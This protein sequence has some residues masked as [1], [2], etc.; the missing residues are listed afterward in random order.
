MA[1]VTCPNCG[2]AAESPQSAG[3]IPFCLECGWHV[4]AN[5]SLAGWARRL[6][7]IIVLGTLIL[8]LEIYGT[9]TFQ[10][11]SEAAWS[12]VFFAFL[13]W[14]AY[15][16][17][18]KHMK[19]LCSACLPNGVAASQADWT[20]HPPWATFETIDPSVS[21]RVARWAA[22]PKPRGVTYRADVMWPTAAVLGV[23]SVFY[24]APQQAWG[25]GV[26]LGPGYYM[27]LV[28]VPVLV[29]FAW[30]Q[31]YARE[32]CSRRMLAEG[33]MTTGRIL[34]RVPISIAPRGLLG[35]VPISASGANKHHIITYKYWRPNGARIETCY[36]Y[37]P[38]EPDCSV[39]LVYYDQEG[40]SIAA[41]GTGYEVLDFAGW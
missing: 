19:R 39:V 36:C 41:G 31:R 35:A 37:W 5:L 3:Q 38:L 40:N 25:R 14:L 17:V 28:V 23:L 15:R 34:G 1:A 10:N 9:G 27:F 32:Q 33:E 29:G 4:G 11:A 30:Y 6:L 12:I 18:V 7:R 24:L 13:F 8:A 20:D 21:E 2:A 22:L 16:S 26:P